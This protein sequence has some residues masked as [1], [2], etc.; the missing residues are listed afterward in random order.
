M[1]RTRT[2]IG[3]MTAAAVLGSGLQLGASAETST[4]EVGARV[5]QLPAE[6]STL[7][8]T[9][10]V[11]ATLDLQMLRRLV[12]TPDDLR[13]VTL[14]LQ[15]APAEVTLRTLASGKA[16]DRQAVRLDEAVGTVRLEAGEELVI[17]AWRHQWHYHGGAALDGLEINGRPLPGFTDDTAAETDAG[18]FRLVNLSV[19]DRFPAVQEQADSVRGAQAGLWVSPQGKGTRHRVRGSGLRLETNGRADRN[20]GYDWAP[21]LVFSPH[22]AG[23]YRVSGRLVFSSAKPTKADDPQTMSYLVGVGRSAGQTASGGSVPSIQLREPVSGAVLARGPI[24]ETT[25]LR[26][27]TERMVRELA[28]GAD[29]LPV[30]LVVNGFSGGSVPIAQRGADRVE[31]VRHDKH[32]LFP[33]AVRPRAGVYARAEGSRLMYG[34]E[35]LRLWGVAGT[36]GVDPTAADRLSRIGFNAMRQWH[37]GG[38]GNRRSLFYSPESGKRGEVRSVRSGGDEPDSLDVY[39][40]FF[41]ACKDAGMFLMLPALQG[42]IPDAYLA[43]PGSFVSGGE[44]WEAWRQAILVDPKS[45]KSRRLWLTFDER[46]LEAQKRHITNFLNLLNPY[47][48]QRYADEEAVA[49]W[50]IHNEH[51]LVKHALE[52]GFDTWPAYFRDK[53]QRRWNRWLAEQ[54]GD[55]AGVTRAWGRL[56][57]GESLG[58]GTV[59][60]GP[61][62]GQREDFPKARASDFVRFIV[63]LVGDYYV[64]LEAHARAQGT[65]GKGV[66]VVPFSYDTQFRHNIPWHYSAAGRADVSNFGM[67]FWQLSSKLTRAP[68]MYVMDALTLADKPTVI[69]ETN[70]GRPNAF[71]GELPFLNALFANHLDWDAVFFHYYHCRYGGVDEDYLA[72]SI[73]M[74]TDTHFWS[75]VE[76]ERDPLML[77]L[78]ALTGQAFLQ[79]SVPTAAD[80]VIYELGERAIFSY[81]HYAGPELA[82]EAFDRGAML[83]FVPDGD[84]AVRR[85][86]ASGARA[87]GHRF[88][89]DKGRLIIDTPTFKAYVGPTVERFRFNDGVVVGGFETDWVAFGMVSADGRP[90]TG[91]DPARSIF[92]NARRDAYNR[93][94]EVDTSG[95]APGGG[96]INPAELIRRTTS[97]GTAP[98]VEDPVAYK[99]WLPFEA[100]GQFE[101]Y[102]FATRRITQRP[103]EGSVLEHD[104]TPLFMGRLLL[105]RTLGPATTPDAD[106]TPTAAAQRLA[107]TTARR[108]AESLA[109]APVSEMWT[110]VDGLNWYMTRE[111]VDR[112]LRRTGWKVERDSIAGTITMMNIDLAGLGRADVRAR[113]DASRLTGLDAAFRQP[114]ATTDLINAHRPL[115]DPT[116]TR[117]SENAF[118]ISTARWQQARGKESLSAVLTATQG[119]ASLEYRYQLAR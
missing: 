113:F 101:G 54:Y 24:E 29:R 68:Q 53:L 98:V 74:G 45:V 5:L 118:E 55:E 60:L 75:A 51:Q 39:H 43:E 49:V 17:T 4:V 78:A 89:P 25:V 115:G 73:P 58:R 109:D 16:A 44:D 20:A 100:T 114:P 14:Q 18:V 103:F 32:Q 47:T 81:D 93:G 87:T 48:G 38:Q 26:L 107:V 97:R 69:Y 96:F 12:V 1:K 86:A 56:E 67:Y 28:T 19:R 119:N 66:A 90:L 84:F 15:T 30:R 23:E 106:E 6:A 111:D 35:R 61:L 116:S 33:K 21:A 59:E 50:E 10:P 40:R 105:D 104:G 80:P 36:G 102:D 110:P 112:L 37:P 13:A 8:A 41:A 34:A 91:E 88:E 92:V 83:R 77:S 2:Q 76:M 71:R 27:D 72:M 79:G 85:R 9:A 108:A 31:L 70:S 22:R 62:L 117:L 52:R 82:D 7:S 42:R 57:P 46:L 65:P 63:T 99:L 94:L 95:V 11:D 64:D 3:V